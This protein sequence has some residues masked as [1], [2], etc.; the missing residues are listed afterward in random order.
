MFNREM[1]EMFRPASEVEVKEII[2]KS[3]N[4]SCDLDPLPGWPL[5]KCLDERLPLITTII[6][7]S[8]DESVL[9]FCMKRA[10]ITPLFKRSVL[11]KEDMKNYPISTFI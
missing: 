11:D 10:R 1:L 4:K 7:G 5:K 2:T 6:N 3:P 8:M 9:P